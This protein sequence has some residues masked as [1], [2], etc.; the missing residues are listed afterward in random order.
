M[1]YEMHITAYLSCLSGEFSFSTFNL[2]QLA[3]FCIEYKFNVYWNR[4]ATSPAVCFTLSGAGGG[5]VRNSKLSVLERNSTLGVT[6]FLFLVPK[7]LR[8]HTATHLPR[9]ATYIMYQ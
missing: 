4:V 1:I 6:I 2:F 9:V 8:I 3:N 7:N 5:I